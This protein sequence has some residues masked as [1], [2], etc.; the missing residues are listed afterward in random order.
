MI[1]RISHFC[2]LFRPADKRWTKKKPLIEGLL[3]AIRER[4]EQR[5]GRQLSDDAVRQ[6]V[7]HTGPCFPPANCPALYACAFS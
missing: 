2:L 7:E 6:N 5:P 3:T 1:K 4:K